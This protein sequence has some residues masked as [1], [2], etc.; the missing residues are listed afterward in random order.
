M[1]RNKL[2]L[3][4]VSGAIV[5]LGQSA[6]VPALGIIASCCGY[7]L[8]WR[9][10]TRFWPAT[11]WFAAVQAVQISWMTETTYMG[12]LIWVVYLFLIAAM[13]AQFGLLSCL[14]P[15][16]L[17]W[18]SILGLAS[19][20]TLFEWVRLFFLSG[21]TWSFAGTA[22]A[23]S[24]TALQWASLWG[25]Y[26]LSFWVTGDNLWKGAALNALQNAE[27]MI[28]EGLLKPKRAAVMT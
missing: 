19:L 9:V 25:I 3:A 6:W 17:T 24:A 2:L 28:R 1:A 21:F 26:G 14:I 15:A 10:T 7:A 23:T 5:A 18:R 27:L 11:L 22:L 16:Q 12:P 20:W 8:F 4:L 13:G